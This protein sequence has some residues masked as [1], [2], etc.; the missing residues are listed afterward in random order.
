MDA[1]QSH[2]TRM[3]D[4]DDDYDMWRDLAENTPA[5]SVKQ[6]DAQSTKQSIRP[7]SGETKIA[8]GVSMVQ[9]V[10]TMQKPQWWCSVYYCMTYRMP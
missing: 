6:L 1:R 9:K 7:E 4:C 8:A 10:V 5:I 3:S 2:K